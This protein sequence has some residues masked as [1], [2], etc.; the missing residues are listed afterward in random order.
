MSELK[1]QYSEEGGFYH[2]VVE[3]R[4]VGVVCSVDNEKYE[5]SADIVLGD[6]VG[7]IKITG[8]GRDKV[9]QELLTFL[10]ATKRL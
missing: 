9:G 10:S 8:T 5:A 2:V 7:S 6:D 1:L 3:N 4:V